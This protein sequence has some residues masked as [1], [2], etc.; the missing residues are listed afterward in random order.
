MLRCGSRGA[1]RCLSL[2]GAAG[3]AHDDTARD[4]AASRHDQRRGRSRGLDQAAPR[5]QGQGGGLTVTA[6]GT[7]MLTPFPQGSYW[8]R[9]RNRDAYIEAVFAHWEEIASVG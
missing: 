5:A 6:W 9:E 2:H 1:R 8:V 3:E 4:R 7:L